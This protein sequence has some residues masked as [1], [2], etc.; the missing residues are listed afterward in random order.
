MQ[1]AVSFH[2][3]RHPGGMAEAQINAFLTH[4]AVKEKCPQPW[5]FRGSQPGGRVLR[6]RFLCCSA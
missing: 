6:R 2:N 1:A 4:L 3:M 5:T